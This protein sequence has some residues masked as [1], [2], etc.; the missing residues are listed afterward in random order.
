MRNAPPVRL[1]LAALI[2]LLPVAFAFTSG[3]EKEKDRKETPLTLI[4]DIEDSQCAFNVH[5]A[6]R[7]HEAMIKQGVPGATD[8]KSCTQHCVKDMGGNYVLVVK[9]D[10]YR[11][12]D[13]G[14]AEKFAGA[15]VKVTGT[16]DSR[17]HTLHIM[18]IEEAK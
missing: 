10:V 15:K 6:T 11:L 7:S 4:G 5:S 8:E 17:T 2:L 13:Q 3:K 12:D 1:L 18:I 16:L 9:N 14:Y